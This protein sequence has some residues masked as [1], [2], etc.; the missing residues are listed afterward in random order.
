MTNGV[1]ARRG[2]LG[3]LMGSAAAIT[4]L[5]A[6]P[7]SLAAEEVTGPGDD[8]MRELTGKH[9]T[10]FDMSAHKNGKPLTQAKNY[11][12]A[13]RDAFKV[14]ERDLNLVIG[15]HG[16]AIPL[17]LTDTMWSR[18]KIGEQYE[19]TDAG[20][21]SAGVRNVFS[22][23][24]SASGGLVTPEQS[25]EVLQ[26]RGVRFLICMN[27][28]A[29]ATKKLAAADLGAP[30]EIRTAL[31]GGLLPGVITVPAMVVALTQLQEH[32]VHYIKIA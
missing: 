10:V 9:R 6:G 27:T 29:G 31:M 11:L 14:P 19:V 22:T 25:V 2:F 18:F 12:D 26:R 21:K 7:R 8:W 3:R 23:I 16:E 13:W 15:I 1:T 5:G 20:T 17:V 30:D 4:L 28:I 24:N 32:G